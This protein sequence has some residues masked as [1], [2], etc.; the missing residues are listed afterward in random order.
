MKEYLIDGNN[1][2]H[3]ISLLA[4]LQKKQ[5][6]EPREML[7]HRLDRYFHNKNVK[8][9]LFFD[10]HI[11]LP[12]KTSKLKIIYSEN[13]PADVLIRK[14][15]EDSANPRNIVAVSS[16]DDIKK[17]ARA[18]SAETMNSEDFAKFLSSGEKDNDDEKRAEGFDN[19]EFK[20]LFG[21]DE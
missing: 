12:I 5:K 2:I 10:G 11:N 16:D 18:C 3:K 8:V 9:Y 4:R 19:E 13:R 21:A 1:L 17:L 14:H 20:R 15:I 7:A 6:Q